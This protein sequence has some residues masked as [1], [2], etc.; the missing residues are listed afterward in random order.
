MICLGLAG[1]L[2][3]F[4]AH[5][6]GESSDQLTSM[7]CSPL[8]KRYRAGVGWRLE[9]VA[10]WLRKERPPRS[11]TVGRCIVV[12]RRVAGQNSFLAE[13]RKEVGA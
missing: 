11:K 2:H 6:Q 8:A 5:Q 3:I 13:I 1:L 10:G 7:H 9:E 4:A 12:C